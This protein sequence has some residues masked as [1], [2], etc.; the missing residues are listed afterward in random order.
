MSSASP[1][2]L[3]LSTAPRILHPY[4]HASRS[5]REL[6]PWVGGGEKSFIQQKHSWSRLLITYDLL[7]QLLTHYI[8]FPSFWREIHSFGARTAAPGSLSEPFFRECGFLDPAG[9]LPSSERGCG[10]GYGKLQIS[11]KLFAFSLS[12]FYLSP[13]G[14][15]D[16]ITLMTFP[17]SP[18]YPGRETELHY[19]LL[20]VEKHGRDLANPW[21]VRHM[22]VYQQ[23][24]FD[25]AFS[26]WIIIHVSASMQE[27]FSANMPINEEGLDACVMLEIKTLMGHMAIISTAVVNWGSYIDSLSEAFAHRVGPFPFLTCIEQIPHTFS[28]SITISAPPRTQAQEEKTI[29]TQRF[30]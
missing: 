21:A 10:G 24:R 5:L 6:T 3:P 13:R 4:L 23:A 16:K 2:L 8:V 25:Q 27:K 22:S 30:H 15:F 26:V 9:R 28:S 17:P 29:Q 14:C 19:S 18:S 12:I 1:L 20:Y 7:R 11:T